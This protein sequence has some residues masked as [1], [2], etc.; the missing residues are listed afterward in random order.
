MNLSQCH[1]EVR[2]VN[3]VGG[4][5]NGRDEDGGGNENIF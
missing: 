5:E 1:L 2:K 4:E 3:E